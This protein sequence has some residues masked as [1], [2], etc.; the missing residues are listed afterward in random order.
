MNRLDD[1]K[2]IVGAQHVLT[3]SQAQ[4]HLTDWRGRYSGQALAV[5]RPGNTDEVA[6]VVKWCLANIFKC[7]FK[8]NYRI[9]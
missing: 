8:I 7:H 3:D 2:N 1:L 4:A 6:Q 5:V 9:L